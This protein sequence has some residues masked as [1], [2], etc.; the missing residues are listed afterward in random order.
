MLEQT[1][2]RQWGQN[3]AGHLTL[4]STSFVGFPPS[5]LPL[6]GQGTAAGW[7]WGEE[8]PPTPG[9]QHAS[10]QPPHLRGKV[11]PASLL[12]PDSAITLWCVF[13]PRAPTRFN[14]THTDC[15]DVHWREALQ[16]AGL[17]RQGPLLL[18]VLRCQRPWALLVGLDFDLLSRLL[19]E[20]KWGPRGCWLLGREMRF[21][22]RW[23]LREPPTLLAS[24]LPELTNQVS[25]ADLPKKIQQ[26]RQG[27]KHTLSSSFQ[28][29]V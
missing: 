24:P 2:R 19:G 18:A 21:P 27:V 16:G 26:Q 9:S 29:A 10:T 14:V 5:L 22:G 15:R 25:R 12:P 13:S 20:R 7:V 11:P 3:R 17:G 8:Q 6:G 4:F 23:F 28:G 1:W